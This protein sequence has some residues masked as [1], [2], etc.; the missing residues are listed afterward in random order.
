[1]KVDALAIFENKITGKRKI[2]HNV[3]FVDLAGYER[4]NKYTIYTNRGDRKI[5]LNMSEWTF[6]ESKYVEKEDKHE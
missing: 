6:L 5:R 2:I 4:I 1:M 3:F